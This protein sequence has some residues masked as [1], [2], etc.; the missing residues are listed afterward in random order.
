MLVDCHTHLD[1][2]DD[3]ELSGIVA[4][5]REAGVG[6]IIVAGTTVESS[7]RCIAMAGADPALLAGVGVHPTDVREPW[8]GQLSRLHDLA[9][10]S[11]R[12]VAVSETG[13]DFGENAPDLALQYRAFR[14][15]VRLA[16]DLRLPVI[17]HSRGLPNVPETHRE[18]LRVLREERGWEVGGAMHYFQGDADV[19]AECLDL[20]FH[21]SLAKPLLRLPHLQEVAAALPLDGI[22]LETDAYPQPFKGKRERWTEPKDVREVATKLA[23]LKGTTL[24]EVSRATCD[25]LLR[26]YRRL[27]G[28]AAETMS[29]ALRRDLS[30]EATPRPAPAPPRYS[31][32]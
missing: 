2:Y 27:G 24:D 23:E 4:R 29:E 14:E 13:L 18:V 15:Q 6:A 17:F 7:A 5:A 31:T 28:T 20:G 8:T 16:R 1:Q 11:P 25:N 19:A 26:L 9:R 30:A 21:V 12:V 10:S 32:P 3:A 22:V